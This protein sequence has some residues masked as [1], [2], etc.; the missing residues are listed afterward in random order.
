[1]IA[2]VLL[3][4]GAVGSKTTHALDYAERPGCFT[5]DGRRRRLNRCPDYL[6]SRQAQARKKQLAV[7]G[8][9]EMRGARRI[10]TV[11]TV[12]SRRTACRASSSAPYAHS[13]T[14][15]RWQAGR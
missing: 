6:T 13:R 3:G 7:F 15:S 4:A 1:M 11:A 10:T 12:R 8:V 2:R 5:A 14:R 9:A